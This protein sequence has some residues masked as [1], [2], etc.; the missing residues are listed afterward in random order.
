MITVGTTPQRDDTCP[1]AFASC[2][3][4]FTSDV[5]PMHRAQAASKAKEAVGKAK[6]E[7]VTLADDKTLKTEKVRLRWVVPQSASSW[8]L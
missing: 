4:R 5:L 7:D 3:H 6:K 1:F 8:Y 2:S